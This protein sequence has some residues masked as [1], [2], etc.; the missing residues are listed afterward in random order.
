MDFKTWVTPRLT[1]K[2]LEILED[3][4]QPGPNGYKAKNLSLAR[5]RLKISSK[6]FYEILDKLE[7]HAITFERQVLLDE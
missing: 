6:T 4:T 5:K 1:K 7:D 3:Y 2:E